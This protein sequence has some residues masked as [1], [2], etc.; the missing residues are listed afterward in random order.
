[1]NFKQRARA[2]IFCLLLANLDRNFWL[3]VSYSFG[4]ILAGYDFQL[5]S[6]S[7]ETSSCFQS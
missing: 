5:I 1:M 4:H 6:C 3:F 2:K 7:F